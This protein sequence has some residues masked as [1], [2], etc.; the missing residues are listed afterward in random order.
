MLGDRR[1]NGHSAVKNPAVSLEGGH[2]QCIAPCICGSA[3][4]YHSPQRQVQFSKV[5]KTDRTS[6]AEG[7]G[8]RRCIGLF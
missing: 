6:S 4:V 2:S 8:A 7:G 1:A 5:R 3:L